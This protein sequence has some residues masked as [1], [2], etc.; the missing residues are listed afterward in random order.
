MKKILTLSLLVFLSFHAFSQQTLFRY[1]NV[2]NFKHYYTVNFNEYGNGA[3]GWVLEGPACLVFN[4]ED[5]ARGIVPLFRY[6]NPKNGDHYYTTHLGELGDG[7][8]GYHLEGP[9]CYIYKFEV[10]GAVPLFRYF[11]VKTGDHFYTIDRRELGRGFDGYIFE[12]IVGFVLPP[13]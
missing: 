11:N 6:F 1:R 4:A 2:K 3:N 10:P 13:R 7:E 5:R 12:K 8:V 9:S